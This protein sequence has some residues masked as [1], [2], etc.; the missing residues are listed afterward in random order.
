[1]RILTWNIACLPKKINIFRNPHKVIFDIVEKILNYNPN[2][3]CLQEVFDF[4][5]QQNII[6]TLTYN[7]YNIHVS[8]SENIISKNGLLTACK[9]NILD[10]NTLDYSNFTGPEY[11]IKKGLLSTKIN[12]NDKDI[13]VHNTHLQSDSIGFYN[14]LCFLNRTRQHLEIVNFF[15]NTYTLEQLNDLHIL[16]GDINDDFTC[17]QL[18]LFFSDLPFKN[19]FYNEEKIVT[20]DKYNQQLD[21]ILINQDYEK[22]YFVENGLK[23]NLSDHNILLCD[24][25]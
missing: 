7:N 18:K 13:Y 19:K 11:L 22:K 21:Y 20:F 9:G 16:C 1:M 6:D 2:I 14:N 23:N 24:I 12:E 8:Y 4:K 15:K 5:I 3:I 17:T 25:Y 10:K